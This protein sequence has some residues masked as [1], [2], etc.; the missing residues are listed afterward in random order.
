MHENKSNMKKIKCEF[1]RHELELVHTLL[2]NHIAEKKKQLKQS[3]ELG[4]RNRE[5]IEE[6]STEI[7]Q[8]A[9]TVECI[10]KFLSIDFKTNNMKKQLVITGPSDDMVGLYRLLVADSGQVLASHFCSNAGFAKGDLSLRKDRQ[11]ALN[12][13]FPDGYEVKFLKH[14]DLTPAEIIK[15]NHAFYKEEEE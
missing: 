8:H 3:V 7:D 14:T 2:S 9:A 15:R 10:E 13:Q 5:V 4:Y 11:E 6:I 1:L 12:E